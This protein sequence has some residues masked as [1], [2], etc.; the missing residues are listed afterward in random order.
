MEYSEIYASLNREKYSI[1]VN[2]KSHS[3]NFQ[4]QI[5]FDFSMDSRGVMEL[6]VRHWQ[7]DI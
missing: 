5:S 7:L 1:Q 4:G 3:I 6:W 2:L